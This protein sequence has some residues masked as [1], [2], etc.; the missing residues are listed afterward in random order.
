M[1]LLS[2]LLVLLLFV[3]ACSK[4]RAGQVVKKPS[5]LEF[6]DDSLGSGREAKNGDL[7]QI[8]FSGWIVRDST[9]LFSDW[10][11]DSTKIMSYIGSTNQTRK[12]MKFVLGKNSFINGIDEGI[13][14]MKEGGYRTIIIPSKLAYGERGL[15]PVI[16]PNSDL[17]FQVQ[18]IEVKDAIIVKKWDV[19]TTKYKTL[20]DGIKYAIVAPG[21]SA[22]ID[23]GDVVTLHYSVFL[24]NGKKFDSSVERGEPLVFAYKEQ[25]LV[26]GFNEAVGMMTKG[27]RA[28]FVIP[29]DLA[30]G[31]QGNSV[32][33]PNATLVFDIE[34]LYVAKRPKANHPPIR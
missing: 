34:I 2:A 24:E 14:G 23:S 16:P 17:R 3:P 13:V 30:Y 7:V 26:K 6:M 18:L 11:K 19:D 33:P 10:T 5:G 4:Q 27:E 31:S 15:P 12:P 29:P 20:S 28:E 25:P 1:K 22:A 32:I 9:N 8:N 21:D